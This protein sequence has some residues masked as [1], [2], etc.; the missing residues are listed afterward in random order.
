MQVKPPENFLAWVVFWKWQFSCKKIVFFCFFVRIFE[1]KVEKWHCQTCQSLK[2]HFSKKNWKKAIFLRFKKLGQ[3]KVRACPSGHSI[4]LPGLKMAIKT[5]LNQ[6]PRP[7]HVSKEMKK[8]ALTKS[9]RVFWSVFFPKPDIQHFF[10][11]NI[12]HFFLEKLVR[13]LGVFILKFSWFLFEIKSFNGSLVFVYN[14]N[15]SK[16]FQRF[17]HTFFWRKNLNFLSKFFFEYFLR[18]NFFPEKSFSKINR[19]N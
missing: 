7:L 15:H 19:F 6:C 10:F 4:L 8:I 13:A 9:Q 14:L 5:R 3:K 16:P 12:Y 1:F 17:F 11:Q 2:W 18:S